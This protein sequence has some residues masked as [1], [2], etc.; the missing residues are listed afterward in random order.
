VPDL[1][2]AIGAR[3]S[4]NGSDRRRNGY[5]TVLEQNWSTGLGEYVYA[6]RLDGGLRVQHMAEFLTPEDRPHAP[7]SAE[8][9]DLFRPE[10]E[11]G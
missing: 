10:E 1:R 6:I 11:A 3:V 4:V 8:L 2:Y 7:M 9:A 5:G